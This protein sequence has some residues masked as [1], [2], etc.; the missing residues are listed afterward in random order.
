MP[1]RLKPVSQQIIVITGATSGIGLASALRLAA[2]GAKLV[3]V[4]RSEATLQKIQKRI[5]D[6]GGE[7]IYAVADVA[8]KD[9]LE[10]VAATAVETYGRIDTWINDAGIG[11]FGRLDEISNADH[12]RLFETNFWGLVHGSLI[13]A[14][15]LKA[16]GGGKIIN[17]GSVVSD[18]AFPLQAMYAASKHAIKGFTDGLRQELH[19]AKAPISVTLIK[20]SAIGTPFGNDARNYLAQE[21]QLPPPLYDVEEVARAIVYACDH[22]IRDIY[23]GGGGRLLSGLNQLFPGFVDIILA[24]H[25][26][27]LSVKNERARGRNDNLYQGVGTGQ[28]RGH[29]LSHKPLRSLYTR[30]V[31]HPKVT[32][33]AVAGLLG[34]F[35]AVRRK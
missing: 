32:A 4:A 25:M 12:R 5:S 13:A 3:L 34:A 22:H 28:I 18:I 26:T 17:L 30:A 33:L 35:V 16:N 8:E 15:H 23:I 2:K 27:R 7:A 9:Q 29:D 14:K 10:R 1:I 11:I 24:S 19:F 31:I 6:A 21:A 20:P